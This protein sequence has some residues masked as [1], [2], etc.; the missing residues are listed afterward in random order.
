MHINISIILDP[1]RRAKLKA[2]TL[3]MQRICNESKAVPDGQSWHK[4]P[5]LRLRHNFLWKE[6]GF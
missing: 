4:Y 3:P 5:G 1:T 6:H 2:I